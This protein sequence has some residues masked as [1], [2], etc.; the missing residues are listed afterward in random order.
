MISVETQ[1]DGA[2]LEV[3]ASGTI[4]SSD[5]EAT[6][7]PA[8]EAAL[9]DHDQIRLLIL[10][11]EEFSG[12]DM[13]AVWADT[14]LGVSHWRGF[15]RIALVTDTGWVQ[16]SARLAS[17]MMPCPMQVFSLAG[18]EEARRWLRESLGAI[19][20]IDLG[21]P[22]VQVRLLGQVDPGEYAQATGD[23]DAMIRGKQGFRLLI[24]LTEFDGWQG[25]SAL[26]AH[27]HLGRTHA[28]LLER[29]AIVGN[30][31]WQHMAQRIGNQLIKADIQYFPEEDMDNAK[32]WLAAG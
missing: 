26:D 11:G 4:S 18:I 23:L 10:V 31:G 12:F 5:Y 16:T 2:I 20:V 24:D 9:A 21:G 6:L 28:P 22:C 25:L 13:S 30:K 7:V 17:P 3:T 27:F 15:D 8:I 29:A 19:H 32:S 1:S 14:K